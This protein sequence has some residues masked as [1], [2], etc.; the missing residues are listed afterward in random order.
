MIN[1]FLT[2][3]C[4]FFC[5]LICNTLVLSCILLC[6]QFEIRQLRAHLAQQDLDLAA[7]RDESI[8]IQRVWGKQSRSFQAVEGSAPGESDDEGRQRNWRT[9]CT[10]AGSVLKTWTTRRLQAL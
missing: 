10:S 5:L 1:F 9:F 6:L 3:R 2:V 4:Q 7:E 8:H